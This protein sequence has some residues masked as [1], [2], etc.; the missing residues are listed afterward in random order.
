MRIAERG[1][2][3]AVEQRHPSILLRDFAAQRRVPEAER[4]ALA[5]EGE[6][7][8]RRVVD[9]RDELVG[10]WHVPAII[11]KGRRKADRAGNVLGE[12]G[13]EQQGQDGAKRES[14]DN[15]GRSPRARLAARFQE[16]FLRR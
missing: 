2:V 3:A 11:E 12:L 5:E 8:E 16:G 14:A 13:R 7:L 9:E 15:Q 10:P 1:G 4:L 6:E